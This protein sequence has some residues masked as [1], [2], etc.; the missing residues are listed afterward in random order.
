MFSCWKTANICHRLG[1]SHP[2]ANEL[3]R[4]SHKK[5]LI[6]AHF[7]EKGHAVSAVT[8]DNSKMKSC[9]PP[10][11][12]GGYATADNIWSESA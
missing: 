9:P 3:L 5:T 2:A 10:K 4:F 12:L 7:I 8:T 1:A 11:F 6:L